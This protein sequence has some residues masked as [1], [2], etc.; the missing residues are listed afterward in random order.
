MLFPGLSGAG[1]STIALACVQAGW[2]FL[3]DDVV[4]LRE[5]DDGGLRAHPFPDEIDLTEDSLRFFPKLDIARAAATHWPKHRI[6]PL[7]IRGLRVAAAARTAALVFPF[8]AEGRAR[9]APV[10]AGEALVALVPNVTRTE[11]RI[12]QRN[13]DVL[14]ALARSVPA[15]RLHIADPL[16]APE[17]V[18][19]LVD[20]P[21]SR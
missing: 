12:A 4:L 18:L 10:S 15:Y 3:G 20:G 6:S 16:A 14:A 17:V 5:H 2:E 13:L 19:G 9:L 21:S 1:K 8:R 7:D 11:R